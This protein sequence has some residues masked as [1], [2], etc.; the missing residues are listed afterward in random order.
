MADNAD[1][2]TEIIE[3]HLSRSLENMKAGRGEGA[4]DCRDCG[5]GIPAQ[6]RVAVPWAVRCV[7]CQEIAEV[8]R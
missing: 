3:G 1:L 5:I 7:D 8:R 2:A 6:R 4:E